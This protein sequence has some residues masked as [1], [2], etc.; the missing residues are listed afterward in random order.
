MLRTSFGMRGGQR[1]AVFHQPTMPFTVNTMA[2]HLDRLMVCHHLDPRIP[3]DVAFADSR[4]RAE[5]IAAEDHPPRSGAFSKMS[6]IPRP[7]ADRCGDSATWQ[8]ANKMKKQRGSLPG[9]TGANDNVGPKRY[10]AK[11]TINRPSPMGFPT[12]WAP[13]RSASGGHCFVGPRLLRRPAETDHQGRLSLPTPRWG[14]P[15]LDSHAPAP[16][17]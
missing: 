8:T 12:M 11:Y 2:E 3:E 14:T 5:T 13:S 10:V 9:E 4:I 1:P 15:T 6:S 16:Y 7:G 17:T